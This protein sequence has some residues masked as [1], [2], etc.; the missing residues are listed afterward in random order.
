MKKTLFV[1]S[2]LFFSSA[3]SATVLSFTGGVDDFNPSG[4][5][6]YGWSFDVTSSVTVTQLGVF[7]FQDNG[8]AESHD[9]GIWDSAGSLLASTLIGS[10]TGALL[11]GGFRYNDITDF[12]L[13]VG[14]N[15]VIAATNWDVDHM[16]VN[17]SSVLTINPI[18]FGGGRY[19]D[20]SG[21]LEMP[22][23][24]NPVNSYF[25]PNFM[26]DITPV[27]LPASV[28]LFGSGL[29]GIIG[30]ARRKK[31]PGQRQCQR[32]NPQ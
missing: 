27:P 7:D 8:L 28:W 3:E 30:L 22:T 6:T 9:V 15:Y 4:T 31:N 32:G 2:L 26:I 21:I 29:I 1:F 24:I 13:N 11:D 23:I 19:S 17:A 20:T 25:G 12:T 5:F 14:T 10:G 18:V 16:I